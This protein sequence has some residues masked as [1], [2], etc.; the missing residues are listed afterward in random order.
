MA[1]LNLS[2]SCYNNRNLEFKSIWNPA[3]I[4]ERCPILVVAPKFKIYELSN[5]EP[6][7]KYGYNHVVIFKDTQG[8]NH[9]TALPAQSPRCGFCIRAPFPEEAESFIKLMGFIYGKKDQ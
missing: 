7:H 3:F 5:V 1:N 6:V 8:V 4:E 2:Y 9:T